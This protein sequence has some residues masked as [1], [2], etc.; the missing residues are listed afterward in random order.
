MLNDELLSSD[1]NS[2]CELIDRGGMQDK[3]FMSQDNFA[4]NESLAYI[5]HSF[6]PIIEK[7]TNAQLLEGI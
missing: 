5:L 6:L 2:L 1:I 7:Q 3:I 4:I